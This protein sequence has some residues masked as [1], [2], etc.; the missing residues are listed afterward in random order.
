LRASPGIKPCLQFLLCLLFLIG[1]LCLWCLL[2]R[3][4]GRPDGTVQDECDWTGVRTD[5]FGRLF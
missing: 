3:P 5:R 4:G 1:L 2:C